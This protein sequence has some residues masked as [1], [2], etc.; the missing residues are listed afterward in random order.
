M[1]SIAKELKV[2]RYT[3]GWGEA[4]SRTENDSYY[5]SVYLKAPNEAACSCNETGPICEVHKY[6][7]KTTHCI[8]IIRN[9]E[10]S[11]FQVLSPCRIR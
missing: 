8:C 6:N 5:S 4:I 1:V 9:D 2:L 3:K 7:K 10:N 11:N